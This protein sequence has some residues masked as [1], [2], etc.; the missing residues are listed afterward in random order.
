M[1]N[2]KFPLWE[3]CN[4]ELKRFIY[5]CFSNKIIFDIEN[6]SVNICFLTKEDIIH[7]IPD[8]FRNIF[9]VEYVKFTK[10]IMN[11]FNL[12]PYKYYPMDNYIKTKMQNDMDKYTGDIEARYGKPLRDIFLEYYLKVY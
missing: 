8:Q 11:N 6:Q 7:H 2:E 10:E 5:H 1:K 4:V 3:D 9:Y 12:I